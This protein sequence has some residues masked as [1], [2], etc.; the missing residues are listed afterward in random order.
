MDAT[1][2]AHPAWWRGH[3]YVSEKLLEI[4]RAGEKKGEQYQTLALQK[5]EALEKLEGD[6]AV[7]LGLAEER[8]GQIT[9]KT[10]TERIVQE[11][12]Y[13]YE[14]REAILDGL[15]WEQAAE[16]A[17]SRSRSSRSAE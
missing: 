11:A 9:P 7:A 4:A 5:T 1:D 3:D 8:E 12:R 14:W 6:L 16:R 13:L 15:N 2:G 10:S 17:T